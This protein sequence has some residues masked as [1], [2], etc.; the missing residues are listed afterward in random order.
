MRVKIFSLV[1]I[2]LLLFSLHAFAWENEYHLQMVKDAVALCPTELRDFLK[3]HMDSVLTGATEPDRIISNP[4]GYAYN[5][6][7]HYYIPEEDKGS[8][9]DEVKRLSLSVIDLFLEDYPDKNVI[10]YRMGMVS[11]YVADTIEPKRYIGVAPRYPVEYL[12]TES[13]MT[14]TYNGYNPIVDFSQDLKDFAADIW[15]RD[16][17]DEEYYDMAVNYIVDVWT[18]IWDKSG[19]PLGDSILVG[20]MIRP[21]P[22]EKE[23]EVTT[24]VIS[25]TTYFDLENLGEEEVFDEKTFDLDKFGKEKGI[26]SSVDLE[27]EGEETLTP[28]SPIPGEEGVEEELED[29]FSEEEGEGEEL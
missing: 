18:S 14:V 17:T 5:Y 28:T 8:A 20:S 15:D 4:T 22:P 6:R 26:D 21:I 11:H 25:P 19:I 7:K 23:E 10:A 13:Y 2:A 1:I 12:M 3:V 29:I 27:T 24:M 9:P 16:L